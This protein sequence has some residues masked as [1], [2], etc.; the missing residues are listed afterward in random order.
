MQWF[1][2][3]GQFYSPREFTHFQHSFTIRDPQKRIFIHICFVNQLKVK[4]TNALNLRANILNQ[5]QIKRFQNQLDLILRFVVHQNNTSKRVS[6]L[7]TIH[8][9]YWSRKND[10]VSFKQTTIKTEQKIKLL[11]ARNALQH[12]QNV[13]QMRA[14][15]FLAAI[16]EKF[17]AKLQKWAEKKRQIEEIK[18]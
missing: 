8:A 9:N 3:S 15:I 4:A 18:G 12:Q 1:V 11:F 13:A 5:I 7:K 10:N 6:A 14:K 17:R 16:Q 2:P